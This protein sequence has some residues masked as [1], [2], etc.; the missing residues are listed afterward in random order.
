MLIIIGIPNAI[1]KHR[2][3]F[4]SALPFQTSVICDT[5]ILKSYLI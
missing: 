2:H 4:I 3:I 1:Y 5:S